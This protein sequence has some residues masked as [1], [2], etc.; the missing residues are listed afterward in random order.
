MKIENRI[1]KQYSNSLYNKLYIFY[2]LCVCDFFFIEDIC[3]HLGISR[4]TIERYVEDIN[5]T[6]CFRVVRKKEY[7]DPNT[8]EI[9]HYPIYTIEQDNSYITRSRYKFGSRIFVGYF[10]RNKHSSKHKIKK[11]KY[12]EVA[13]LRRRLKFLYE[14]SLA[15]RKKVRLASNYYNNHSKMIDNLNKADL[16][17]GINRIIHSYYSGKNIRTLKR[18]FNLL[19]NVFRDVNIYINEDEQLLSKDGIRLININTILSDEVYMEIIKMFRREFEDVD[20]E[21]KSINC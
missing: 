14:I 19:F 15:Q 4:R 6:R 13:T 12:I 5:S 18:D 11:Y 2:Y 21:L 20:R 1:K 17:I 9:E 7:L 3:E 16:F 8:N 10:S